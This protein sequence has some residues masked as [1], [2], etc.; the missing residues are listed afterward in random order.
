MPRVRK[1]PLK[2]LLDPIAQRFAVEVSVAVMGHV[3]ARVRE[4]VQAVVGRAFRGQAVAARGRRRGAA[5]VRQLRPCRVPGCGRPSKGP[6]FDYFCAQHRELPAAE[7]DAIKKALS[8]T[9]PA[10]AAPADGAAKRRTKA[11]PRRA[12]PAHRTGKATSRTEK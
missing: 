3:E 9:A 11:R 4:E 12:T 10:A 6:R 1:D 7:K 2:S 5:P 8:K